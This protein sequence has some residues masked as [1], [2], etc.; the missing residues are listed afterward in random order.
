MKIIKPYYIIET[1]IDGEY[2]LKLIE[3]A[4]RTCYKSEN[5]IT[6]N[7]AKKFVKNLIERGHLSVIEHYSVSVRIICDRG[8]SHELVRHRPASYTQES[9]RY[10][11]YAKGK[12]DGELTF[13]KPCFWQ[14]TKST[15][16]EIWKNVMNQCEKDYIRLIEIGA[17]P[18]EAR[19]ILP[20]S[21]KTEIL[22]TMNLREWRHFFTLRTAQASH[23]QMREITIPLL[24]ELKEKIPVVFDDIIPES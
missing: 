17:T 7:S 4:G 6:E 16:Y 3:K 11:N 19:S 15:E 18:Q 20:N 14:N 1:P 21:L 8:V 23:P 24:N 22:V 12:F 2:I 9:T 10:C 13:I 5:S